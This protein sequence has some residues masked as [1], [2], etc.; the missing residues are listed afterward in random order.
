MCVA[1]YV[2]GCCRLLRLKTKGPPQNLDWSFGAQERGQG[3]C[4][5]SGTMFNFC[6][7]QTACIQATR[8]N[9]RKSRMFSHSAQCSH[10]AVSL[11]VWFYHWWKLTNL[12]AWSSFTWKQQWK[13]SQSQ[14]SWWPELR[15]EFI[16]NIRPMAKSDFVNESRELWS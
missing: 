8:D 6:F 4:N 14:N 15:R 3:Q 2:W 13:L 5:R 7:R 9:M 12:Q 16:E 1:G 10:S 11:K